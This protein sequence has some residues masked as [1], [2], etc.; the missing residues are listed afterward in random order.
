MPTIIDL[1][2]YDVQNSSFS[3]SSR[4]T[5]KVKSLNFEG[6]LEILNSC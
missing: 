4:S 3:S 5:P 6:V 1:W 2:G